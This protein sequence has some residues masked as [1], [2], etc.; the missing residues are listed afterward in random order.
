VPG[1]LRERTGSPRRTASRAVWL[2]SLF[3][4][5]RRQERS[6]TGRPSHPC[7]DEDEQN[8]ECHGDSDRPLRHERWRPDSH[9]RQADIHQHLAPASS[10]NGAF[11]SRLQTL[12]APLSAAAGISWRSAIG[13]LL[14]DCEEDRI[15]RAV[16][17]GML[18]DAES[19]RLK[20]LQVAIQRRSRGCHEVDG[21]SIGLRPEPVSCSR[22]ATSLELGFA[23]TGSR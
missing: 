4:W 15:L 9:E 19:E 14:T 8:A 22:P 7:A 13:E 21:W 2:E 5:G 6:Y 1:S 17:V 12:H 18:R 20:S 16:L 10:A 11:R 3:G 23:S